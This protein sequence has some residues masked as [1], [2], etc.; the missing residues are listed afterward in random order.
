MLIS[1][2]AAAVALAPELTAVSALREVRDF[3]IVAPDIIEGSVVVT[4]SADRN[5]D[6]Q[7]PNEAFWR[8][9]DRTFATRF[10]W[11]DPSPRSVTL[12]D[13]VGDPA[14]LDLV[15]AP[16]PAYDPSTHSVPVI[17]VTTSS[18]AD[19][20]D[21]FTGI[22]VW[23]EDANF[24]QRGGDWERNATWRLSIGGDVLVDQPIGLRIHGGYS[25]F[26]HQK[27]L[28]CYFDDYGDA[29]ELAYDVFGDGD[30]AL[31]ERLVLRAN[32]YDDVAIN[33]NLAEGWMR[34]EDHLGSR[35]RFA[36]VYLNDEYWGAYSIRERLDSKFFET[37]HGFGGDYVLIKDNE[38][39]EG[40]GDL[41]WARQAALNDALRP[42]SAAFYATV[43][44]DID[45][46]SYIDWLFFN[47]LAVSGDNGFGYNLVIVRPEGGRWTFVMW[48]ED[49]IFRSGD[50]QADM[51]RYFSAD[52]QAEHEYWRAP[53]DVRPWDP[54]QQRWQ[55]M[56][57]TLLRNPQFRERLRTRVEEL[58]S[59]SLSV[60]AMHERL[61]AIVSEQISEI[62]RHAQRW[63]GFQHDWYLANVERTRDWIATRV[64]V[65]SGQLGPFLSE[66]EPSV[67]PIVLSVGPNPVHQELTIAFAVARP[68]G[69]ILTIH[70][71]RG[72][73]VRR[74]DV[75]GMI[76]QS[77]DL[78][79]DAGRSVPSG[80]Y[81]L[82]SGDGTEM[83]R[84][85]VIH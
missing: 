2:A 42:E 65:V 5:V 11:D 15:P 64:P 50:E 4:V 45:L 68:A 60:A 77:W 70:D 41:W 18:A 59:G 53:N 75:G 8:V 38:T 61:D 30:S 33:T 40:D 55:T 37:T 3:N 54:A 35:S 20:W 27:G 62:P 84:V 31:F 80:S 49:S 39:E 1:I 47:I 58:V 48:D 14:S 82:R 34:D 44:A 21:H 7:T 81:L 67:V 63:E 52:G 72:R 6:L 9:D 71:L 76:L 29:D 56:F 69:E 36:A 17:H 22:Y 51:F 10:L 66:Y 23:G 57:R 74:L 79:D 43:D 28:R 85:T 19:L 12:V 16:G 26:Y 24:N 78:R 32:R 46:A 83:R 25:R 13:G 73:R